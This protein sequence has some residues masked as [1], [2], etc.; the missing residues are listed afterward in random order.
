LGFMWSGAE[1]SPGVFNETYFDI[2]GGIVD[3]LAAHGITPFLDVH[4]DVLSTR[5]CLYDAFPLWYIDT[6]PPPEH[7]FSWPL[8]VNRAHHFGFYKILCLN[9]VYLC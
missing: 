3:S 2:M 8:K 4:Q 5:Y 7:A 1:P 9:N 6:A